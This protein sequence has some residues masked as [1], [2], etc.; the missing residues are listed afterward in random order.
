MKSRI[1][2]PSILTADFSNLSAQIKELEK[3]GA[4]WL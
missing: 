4:D 2:A 3:G 1:L